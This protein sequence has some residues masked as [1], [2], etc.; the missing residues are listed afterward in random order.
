[1]IFGLGKRARGPGQTIV[2]TLYHITRGIVTFVKTAGRRVVAR[3]SYPEGK[4]EIA[5]YW[6]DGNKGYSAVVEA[7]T[8]YLSRYAGCTSLA[9]FPRGALT[10]LSRD[11]RVSETVLVRGGYRVGR[12]AENWNK[13]KRESGPRNSQK[14]S[15]A[16]IFINIGGTALAA[17]AAPKQSTQ[18][19]KLQ[20]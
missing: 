12:V 14:Y 18:N 9:T 17:P 3:R 16:V 10:W 6:T 11:N 20:P 7:R 1:M 15:P 4:V 5:R 19:R 2:G 8:A 13:R